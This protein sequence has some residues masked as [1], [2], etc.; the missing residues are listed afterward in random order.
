MARKSKSSSDE[1]DI[2]GSTQ[3]DNVMGYS[4][5]KRH[6]LHGIPFIFGH[7]VNVPLSRSFIQ[8]PHKRCNL[9]S[10]LAL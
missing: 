4:K 9:I 7:K 5:L 10:L 1:E 6:G 8:M 3:I 2:I